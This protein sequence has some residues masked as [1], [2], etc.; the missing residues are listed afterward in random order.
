MILT[1]VGGGDALYDIKAKVGNLRKMK[2]RAVGGTRAAG[3]AGRLRVSRGQSGTLIWP[4]E[5]PNLTIRALTTTMARPMIHGARE[6]TPP[7]T[8]SSASRAE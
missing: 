4:S 2:L 1:C 8:A 5:S 6:S 3:V 7:A